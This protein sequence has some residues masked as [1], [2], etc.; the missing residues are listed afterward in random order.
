MEVHRCEEGVS[1]DIAM[2]ALQAAQS[3]RRVGDQELRDQIA[4]ILGEE[5]RVGGT[6]AQDL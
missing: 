4:G 6:I 5:G 1:G 3:L 2:A